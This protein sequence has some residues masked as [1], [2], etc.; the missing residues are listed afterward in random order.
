MTH[1]ARRIA[2]C[3]AVCMASAPAALQ[4]TSATDGGARWRA[5]RHA[6]SGSA[7]R[8][9]GFSSAGTQETR[10]KP[11]FLGSSGAV[12]GTVQRTLTGAR[13]G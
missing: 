1:A 7:W 6:G 8:A 11:G 13:P 3:G 5:G 12:A 9:H 2:H 10:P 4:R